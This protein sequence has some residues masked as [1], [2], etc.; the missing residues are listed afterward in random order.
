MKKI[1]IFLLLLVAIGLGAFV[2]NRAQQLNEQQVQEAQRQFGMFEWNEAAL[3]DPDDA[4]QLITELDIGRWYQ[5]M[6]EKIEVSAVRTF[7]SRLHEKNVMVYSLIGAVDWGFEK[8]GRS[9]IKRIEYIVAYNSKVSENEQI[10]GVM[11]DVEPYTTSKW[12]KNREKNMKTYVSGMTA[13]YQYARKNGIKFLLCI[14]R[15]YDDQ[16]LT[17]QL[18][19]LIKE[20]CDEVAVMDYDCG[21][22]ITKIATEAAFAEKYEKILHCILEFQE[23]GKHGLTENK[24]YSNK[25]LKAAQETWDTMQTAFQ[26]QKIIFD[27]HWSDPVRE[28]LEKEK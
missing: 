11:V 15:H 20:A 17:G 26:G 5:E 3:N 7:V 23:V 6:P 10:I 19:V 9:L 22:E 13:A 18:E 21:Q 12:A 25:G 8:D 28:L 16:G 24:T 2:F 1:G 4:L 14:P 27:Y